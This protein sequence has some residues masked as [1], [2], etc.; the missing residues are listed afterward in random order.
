LAA[1][2]IIEQKDGMMVFF[3]GENLPDPLDNS[4]SKDYNNSSRNIGFVKITKKLVKGDE[5]ILSEGPLQKGGEDGQYLDFRLR[6]SDFGFSTK[7]NGVVA[8][9]QIL[10]CASRSIVMFMYSLINSQFEMNYHI[11]K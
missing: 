3:C 4:H 9:I 10:T 11:M 6:S 1:P 7:Q 2:G 5:C 8:L